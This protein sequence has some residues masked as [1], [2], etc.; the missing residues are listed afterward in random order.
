MDRK[1][2]GCPGSGEKP[3]FPVPSALVPPHYCC[4][5]AVLG[6]A[7]GARTAIRA[8]KSARPAANRA[9]SG[10]RNLIGDGSGPIRKCGLA[11]RHGAG[12]PARPHV[13]HRAAFLPVS[14]RPLGRRQDLAAAAAVPVAQ[15]DARADHPVRPRRRHPVEGRGGDAAPAH[16]HRVPGFPA[17]RPHDA[18]TR[19]S[20]CRCG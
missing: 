10:R 1:P 4:K 15:A 7:C 3:R 17:A 5:S 6:P 16:R 9:S 18:P 13:P 19:T 12:G 2:W 8:P 20:R 11:L 14:H